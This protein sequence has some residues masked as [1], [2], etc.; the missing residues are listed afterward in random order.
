MSKLTA[1]RA[2][3]RSFAALRMTLRGLFALLVFFVANPFL[4]A[5]E[6][7]IRVLLVDGYSNHDWKLT[8]ALIRG[9]LEPTG[10]F[11]VT[12][13]TAPATKDAPD[14]DAWRPKFADY[15]V[16]IQTCNDLGGKPTWPRAVQEDFEA[17]V[18]KGGGVYV[19]HSGNNA[20]PDW[21]AYN[22]M[23]GLGWRK[24]DFGEALAID[25]D[26]KVVRIPAGVGPDTGHGARV[27]TVVK[28]LGD[29]P[30][31]AG[32]PR[33]WLTPD[34]EVYYYARGPA[35]D[36]TVLSYGFDPKTQMNWPLE[37]TV[38]YGQGRVYT[39]T[40]G[41]VWK[42]DTQPA[43][44]RCAGV[45]TVAIRALQW[46]AKR[47]VTLPV[48]ADF[49]TAEQASVRPEIPL[50]AFRSFDLATETAYS[51]ATGHGFEADTAPNAEG[52]P[53][54]YSVAVPEGNW[55]VTVTFG[56]DTPGN[57]TVKAESRRLM[58][59][60]LATAAGESVTRSF[61]V[62]V[63]NPAMAGPPANAPGGSAVLLNDREQG[64][65][66]WDD[67]LTFE[68]NGPAPRV[69]RVTL[70]PADVPTVFLLGDSTVTDQRA[71]DGASWGQML[72]R[73]LRPE[74]A[75][76]NHA[77]SGETL[78]SFV[79]GLRLAKVLSQL[80]AHDW[81][82]IQFGHND[83]KKQWPQTYV[84]AGTTYQAWL[85][86]FIAEVRLRGATPVLV[87][88]PQRRNFGP[89]G[90]IKNTHGDYP[91]AVRT[92]AA[93][94]KVALI[95]LEAASRALYEAL[96]PDKSPLAFS[97]G[98]KDVTHHNN[99][100]AYELAKAVAQGIR[101]AQ[102][103]LEPFLAEDFTGFDPA[104]PDDPATFSL[105]A[106]PQKTSERPRGN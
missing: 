79:S 91:A 10:L 7:P 80:K 61:I 31:H 28:R 69:R 100:G 64:S 17:Y 101:T 13:S 66:T 8:T 102:L 98:G 89:D 84:E 81:V 82:F 58:V 41:H 57:T 23:I 3:P 22:D 19:W 37:W 20:F 93:S 39:S 29:H 75:V 83:Q 70:E 103:S 24:K 104:Q 106:S 54:L 88:S 33:A 15:D 63:R 56:G 43:R 9:F 59:E 12:V 65:F 72:P 16:V 21:P 71:E 74:V 4:A 1:H 55:R 73:F 68:F 92:V 53:F 5:A 67:K 85:R 52:K 95:D 77:E 14:W 25:A 11:Q 76:A 49:P 97:N 51:P 48:P 94:E 99:Y 30:I 105:P 62:N 34:I 50:P 38:S 26:G 78:K 47:E 86:T 6:P 96:G 87:T 35:K 44:M 45:Q 46:L 90:K 27:D 2:L 32:L 36:L 18:R 42:G 60:G 40:F